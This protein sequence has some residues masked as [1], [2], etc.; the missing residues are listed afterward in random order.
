MQENKVRKVLQSEEKQICFLVGPL[1][2]FSSFLF[3]ST[4][5][6][7][8][9]NLL[10]KSQDISTLLPDINLLKQKHNC[11]TFFFFINIF[12]LA[13][14]PISVHLLYNHNAMFCRSCH[15]PFAKVS[16]SVLLL[17]ILM[18]LISFSFLN[19]LCSDQN[20]KSYSLYL[21]SNNKGIIPPLQTRRKP[22]LQQ[23]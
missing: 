8:P 13:L 6:L 11:R 2:S 15:H 16:N 9:L 4:R 23:W 20:D 17:I 10:K 19:H 1:I 3:M 12:F 18:T 7:C 22:Q 5:Q 21:P 14:T